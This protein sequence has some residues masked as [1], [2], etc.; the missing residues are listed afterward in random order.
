MILQSTDV[1]LILSVLV[2][3]SNC[4][5]LIH[6][7]DGSTL[8]LTC[9]SD[10]V[11]SIIRANYGRLSHNICSNKSQSETWSTRC[12]QPT[13]LRHI[14]STCRG[15]VSSCNIH[16]S[17]QQFGDPCPETPKYLEVV[18]TCKKKTKEPSSRLRVPPWLM[19]LETMT[20]IIMEK[21]L[22]KNVKAT[23]TTTEASQIIST[24]STPPIRLSANYIRRPSKEFLL[25]IKQ[26]EQQKK[27]Q[28]INQFLNKPSPMM[29]QELK[30][31]SQLD[32]SVI[33][34][35]GASVVLMVLIISIT[36]LLIVFRKKP[37][38]T[39]VSDEESS[40]ASSTASTYLQ[41]SV[42]G[43]QVGDYNYVMDREGRI[44]QVIPQKTLPGVLS[45]YISTNEYE[46]V[47]KISAI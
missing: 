5:K 15:H 20:D 1:L 17:S 14:K 46:D 8:E 27:Q 31:E 33:A 32:S 47:D 22:K 36:I 12:I 28:R 29:S 35:I 3:A 16:V 43:S 39:T 45:S 7:C 24:T 23:T 37:S 19:S 2:A 9:E 26:L 44:Y 10:E 4:R 41:Y 25:Y 18:Y 40:D 38:S 11:L 6:G 21:N 30:N 42:Q 34:A 13:S